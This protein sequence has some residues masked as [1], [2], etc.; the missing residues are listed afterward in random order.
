[1]YSMEAH[2]AGLTVNKYAQAELRPLIMQL[3][4]ASGGVQVTRFELPVVA[5][6]EMAALTIEAGDKD[7][8][9]PS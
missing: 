5:G 6:E 1:M 8:A 2:A 7:W 4:A 9:H 3:F